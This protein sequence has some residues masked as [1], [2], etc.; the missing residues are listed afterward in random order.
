MPVV[1]CVACNQADA[2]PGGRGEEE[3]M[4]GCSV[5]VREGGLDTSAICLVALVGP[6]AARG[7]LLLRPRGCTGLTAT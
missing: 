2:P 6:S 5:I 7:P 1:T 4:S 3:E